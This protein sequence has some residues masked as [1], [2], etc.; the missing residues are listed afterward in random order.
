MR[1]KLLW[2][3][4]LLVALAS[5]SCPRP[6]EEAANCK[7]KCEC[8]NDDTD[9]RVDCQIAFRCEGATETCED[10]FSSFSCEDICAEYAANA[11]CGVA[12]CRTDADCTKTLSCPLAD[13]TGTPTGQFRDCTINF[14]CELDQGESCE[15]AS[16]VDD[17]TFCQACLAGGG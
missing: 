10:A 11:R 2:V 4:P 12:R 16:G 15:P 14:A 17:V 7:R 8:L 9:Q 5:S 6:C 13:N 1:E 3:V